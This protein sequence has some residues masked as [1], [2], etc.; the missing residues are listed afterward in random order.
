MI[1]GLE[2]HGDYLI[3]SVGDE[4]I[5]CMSAVQSKIISSIR[6]V[7]SSSEKVFEEVLDIY[8]DS[9]SSL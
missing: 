2:F 5:V 3:P 4:S 7:N 6:R 1:C 8:D 9:V